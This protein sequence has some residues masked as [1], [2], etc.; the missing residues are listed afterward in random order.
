MGKVKVVR[1]RG[2]AATITKMIVRRRTGFA[3]NVNLRQSDRITFD[4]VACVNS[5]VIRRLEAFFYRI[6]SPA[7]HFSTYIYWPQI[8]SLNNSHFLVSTSSV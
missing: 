1:V 4:A 8:V 6:D 7:K 5:N 2:A 3:D